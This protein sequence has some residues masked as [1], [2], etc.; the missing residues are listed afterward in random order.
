MSD[1][2]RSFRVADLMVAIAVIGLT[3]GLVLPQLG[4]HCGEPARRMQCRNNVKQIGLA[5][6]QYLNAHGT[7]PNAGTFAE[8]PAALAS[9]NPDDSVIDD[10]FAGRRFGRSHPGAPEAGPRHSW[11]A[12]ILPYLGNGNLYNDFN[13]ER[14][15][16]DNGRPGDDPTR[17]S[18][19]VISS[20]DIDILRCPQ[21]N[22]ILLGQGNLSYVVNGGFSRWHAEGHAYGWIGNPTGGINGPALDWGQKVATRTG[23]MFLGTQAGNAPWDY[24]TSPG[25]ITD[26]L[27]STLLLAENHLA[28]ASPGTP[29]SSNVPTN[30]ACPHPN[31]CMFV[32]SDDVCTKGTFASLNCSAVN[33]LAETATSGWSSGWSRT[34]TA[35]SPEAINSGLTHSVVGSSPFP[36]SN[37]PGLIVVGMCDGSSRTISAKIEGSVYAKLITPAGG[38][39]PTIYRQA[40]LNPSDY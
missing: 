5:L 30:W 9:G 8:D 19:R 27:S 6:Q 31:F 24:T 21:D 28:G 15:Y 10:A 12:N 17:P 16:L 23:V 35:G 29:Y 20:T 18:N 32:A 3:L 2:R 38:Q 40:Q 33:D 11:V 26:G 14:S 39:L 25:S 22:T 7:F 4:T 36:N 13:F 37:H 34:N 1:P